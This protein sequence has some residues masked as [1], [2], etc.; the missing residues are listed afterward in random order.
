MDQYLDYIG[1]PAGALALTGVAAASAFYLASRP[2]PE[3]PLVELTCQS[4]LLPTSLLG[5][6]IL[7]FEFRSGVGAR[8]V[9]EGRGNWLPA[10]IGARLGRITTG[11]MCQERSGPRPTDWETIL[12]CG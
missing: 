8:G 9:P 4:K 3:K 11:V 10:S 2:S 12:D 5:T 1:G 6:G 7:R